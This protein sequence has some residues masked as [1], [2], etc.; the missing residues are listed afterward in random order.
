MIVCLGNASVE[1]LESRLLKDLTLE[2]V[3]NGRRVLLV[4]QADLA[5]AQVALGDF[6]VALVGL[7]AK[8]SNKFKIYQNLPHLGPCR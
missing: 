6:D 7:K 4:L 2:Q 1:L 3:A 5:Q 8:L